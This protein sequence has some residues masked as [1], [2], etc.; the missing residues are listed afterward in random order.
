MKNEWAATVV[1]PELAAVHNDLARLSAPALGS[2]RLSL[3]EFLN[4]AF[5]DRRRIALAFL[6]AMALT[7]LASF[8]PS[9]RYT[10][11]SSLLL[12][13]GR[14]YMYRPEVGAAAAASP[15]A[16][17]S[18]ETLRAEVEILNSRDI[19]E[20][21][22]DRIGPAVVY[23]W[24]A[25]DAK[26]A[27]ELR[28]QAVLELQHGFDAKLIKD[29]NVAVL[30]FTHRDPE[31]AARVLAQ[32][33]EA[34]LDHRRTIFSPA[35]LGTAQA[36]ADELAG[37]LRS[38]ETRLEAF[39]K[40]KGIQSFSEQQSLLITQRN[41]IEMRLGDIEQQLA[42]TAGRAASLRSS[43]GG[44][45]DQMTLSSETQRSEALDSARKSLLDLK[46][47]ERDLS[48]KFSDDVPMVQ[49]VRADIARTEAFIADLQRNPERLVR[50]GR[51]PVLDSI[52]S[53]WLRTLAEQRQA[54]ASRAT[55]KAQREA[56]D[57]RLQ[58]LASSQ[59]ELQ[60]L[61]RERKLVEDT[62]QGA[63]QRLEEERV[64]HGLERD[65]RSSVSVVQAP[66]VPLEGRNLQPIILAVGAVL[67]VV[68]ALLV[69][70][71]TALLRDTFISPEQV[72]RELGLPLLA[73]VPLVR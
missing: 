22:V 52:E 15:I 28:D 54:N 8:M 6:A 50:T 59:R 20:A 26:S 39:K 37:R 29:S 36:K 45:N 72:P 43:L 42:Q 66:R 44:M 24:L 71:V 18:R 9:P 2:S 46:L 1:M 27:A 3:R 33:T 62:Y 34:Y 65:R 19:K 4:T 64:I 23:P 57:Q 61:E 13:L 41:G 58:R 7:V 38:L 51:S 69:A 73:A 10:A 5:C 68:C 49:D 60:V 32:I 55:L 47:K 56:I 31:M 16:Y 14:E 35:S 53:D 25:K 12:R 17:D 30:T 40:D 11:E 70:F 48:S 67:S 21:A 63:M